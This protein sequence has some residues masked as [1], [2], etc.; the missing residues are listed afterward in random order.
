MRQRDTRKNKRRTFRQR[1][2]RVP[3]IGG[4]AAIDAMMAK[5]PI[6]KPDLVNPKSKFVVCTYWWGR[7]NSNK[8]YWRFGNEVT[9]A[10]V[11]EGK[12][13]VNYECPSEIS[14]NLKWDYL[15]EL[16]EEAG[17]T[18]DQAKE[19][20]KKTLESPEFKT[21]LTNLVNK[22]LESRAA[23]GEERTKPIKME[24][25][26]EQWKEMCRKANCNFLVQE[27]PF[28]RGQYQ[29]AINMKPNFIAA[30][31]KV[32]S[33]EG[34]G[35]LYIDGDMVIDRYPDIFDMPSVDFMARG[36]NCDPR[37]SSRYITKGICFDPYIFETSG[38]IMYFAPTP[39]AVRL[40]GHWAWLSSFPAMKGKA[41]DRILSIILTT[42]REHDAISTVQ[43]PIEYLWL[44][45]A[46]LYH[47]P[48][49][50]DK[51]KIYV[52]HPACLTS[53]EAA[54][55]QG[56]ANS[57][58]PPQYEELIIDPTNC[59]TDGGYFYEYVYFTER[60]FVKTF[61]PYLNYLRVAKN[62]NGKSPINVIDFE[63]K[64]GPYNTVSLRNIDA[65]KSVKLITNQK[66][67]TLPQD[68]TVPQI[69]A[70]LKA[71][72][73]VIV[74]EFKN[75]FS[76]EYDII[77]TNNG[78]AYISDYQ[79]EIKI[80]TT[81]PMYF[82]SGNPVVYH[83]LMMCRTLDD[84]NMHFK[85]SYLFSSRIRGFWLKTDRP[86]MT[87]EAEKALKEIEKAP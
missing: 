49:H 77:A 19:W 69:L 16:R 53:E 15:D 78:G 23:K 1:K 67:V 31:L 79:T 39:Q 62:R 20:D 3:I 38:G 9:D 47:D 70:N 51:S 10:E 13:R 30:A 59:E 17:I 82:G 42:E 33:R 37:S 29:T 44:T 36:W 24:D 54:R 68:A 71:G 40:L 72:L 50:I 18:N 60:R 83:L 56:A 5:Y 74:G 25:M 8:N 35:V 27:Y 45:D 32:A 75:K 41:D 57:R 65:M 48:S 6:G 7:G 63:D 4:D 43:L 34:R 76:F 55:E 22:T 28:E 85:Q 66:L 73:H 11:K 2:Y 46:Y 12:N 86:K 52:S 81:Q 21:N 64:Y 58:E 87:A 14:D 80:D 61:E 26:I 84:M